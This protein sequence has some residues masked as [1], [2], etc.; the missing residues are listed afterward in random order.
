MYSYT[1]NCCQRCSQLIFKRGWWLKDQSILV[2]LTL[3]VLAYWLDAA[4][5]AIAS[6]TH[7]TE[8]HNPDDDEYDG[9]NW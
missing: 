4:E 8:D 2:A 1:A 3:V 5:V 7:D 9:Y 6:S